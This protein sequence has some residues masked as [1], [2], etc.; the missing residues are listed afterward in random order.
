MRR[1][2]L[3]TALALVVGALAIWMML[4]A[5]PPKEPVYQGKKLSVWMK[6]YASTN[7][8]RRVEAQLAIRGMG[9]NAVPFLTLRLKREA[10]KTYWLRKVDALFHTG[11]KFEQM[12][13][14]NVLEGR[15]GFLTLWPSGLPA[16]E[17]VMEQSS[18]D[19]VLYQAYLMGQVMVMKSSDSHYRMSLSSNAMVKVG[20]AL[21]KHGRAATDVQA[22]AVTAG[23]TQRPGQ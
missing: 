8:D 3:S 23:P 11:T 7:S 1:L 17:Q 21:A 6:N 16:L 9:S 19:E 20:A 5:T 13:A 2:I 15:R 14:Q 22:V 18:N 4:A 12:N 10:Q